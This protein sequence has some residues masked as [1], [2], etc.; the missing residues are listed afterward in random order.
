MFIYFPSSSSK[1][2]SSL[3][4]F[5]LAPFFL[6]SFLPLS[7]FLCTLSP[8][9]NPSFFPITVLPHPP[10]PQPHPILSSSNLILILPHPRRR[11]GWKLVFFRDLQKEVGDINPN[12][13]GMVESIACTRGE[14]FA[15]T[16]SDCGVVCSGPRVDQ[17]WMSG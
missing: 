3:Y 7:S 17:V 15:G 10:L 12:I 5:F 14:V 13:V 2:L 8:S 9:S 4:S 11:F 16:V 1:L 6:Y